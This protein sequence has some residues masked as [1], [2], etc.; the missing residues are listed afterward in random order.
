M[1]VLSRKKGESI[2][3][4]DNIEITIVETG[5]DQVKI[6]IVAPKEIEILRKE[7]Y[8]SVRESNEQSSAP[9]AG[10]SVLREQLKKL[11]KKD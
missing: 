6:G 11:K 8:Q 4:Q 10:L 5:S 2:I 3:L 9:A 7:L 1:L